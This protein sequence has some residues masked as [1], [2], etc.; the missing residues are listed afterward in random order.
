MALLP[1][2]VILPFSRLHI[3]V[4]IGGQH[5]GELTSTTSE[6]QYSWRRCG[7]LQQADDV[8][9]CC[10]LHTV[11]VWFSAMLPAIWPDSQDWT[12]MHGPV[13]IVV[14]RPGETVFVPRGWWHA[15]I[16]LEFSVALTQNFGARRD[17]E[18]VWQSMQVKRRYR[19]GVWRCGVRGFCWYSGRPAS[20]G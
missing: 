10:M 20:Y 1:S 15:V 13:Q 6:Y 16:N 4:I 7:A 2:R 9:D 18:N 11:Q 8:V 19:S 14:Q 3:S 5:R 12:A 17:F